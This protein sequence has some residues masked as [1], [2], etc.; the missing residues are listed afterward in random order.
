VNVLHR[1]V[2]VAAGLTVVVG[3]IGFG[4]LAWAGST[5]PETA[6]QPQVTATGNAHA[7]AL[8]GFEGTVYRKKGFTAITNPTPGVWCLKLPSTI[9][10]T[11]AVPVVSV[12]FSHSPNYDIAAQ[13]ASNNA[14]CPGNQIQVFTFSG[15]PSPSTFAN[16]AFSIIVP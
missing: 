6:V 7:L 12:E 10:A 5:K 15:A 2:A 8:V 16:E 14:S 11:T 1:P 4:G 9:K 13:W 3:A